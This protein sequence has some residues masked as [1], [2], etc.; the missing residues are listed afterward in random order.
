[1]PPT[2][3][4]TADDDAIRAVIRLV[5]EKSNFWGKLVRILFLASGAKNA[6]YGTSEWK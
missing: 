6:C 5:F 1:M 4:A 3:E 2:S